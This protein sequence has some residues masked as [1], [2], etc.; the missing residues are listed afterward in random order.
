M[1]TTLFHAA[2]TASQG[3]CATGII[4]SPEAAYFVRYDAE[5]RVW[6]RYAEEAESG[7]VAAS[8][9]TA[10]EAIFFGD[11]RQV[12]WRH[13]SDGEGTSFVSE[14]PTDLESVD[15]QQLLW[16]TAVSGSKSENWTLTTDSRIGAL[17]IPIGGVEPGTSLCLVQRTHIKVGEYGNC[18]PYKSRLVHLT[19][20]KDN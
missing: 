18:Y 1:A 17:A 12:T 11:A 4:Y 8:F 3:G 15:Q 7:E 6:L 14:D 16:G 20:H 9:D 19:I 13:E 2:D 10:F 5:K